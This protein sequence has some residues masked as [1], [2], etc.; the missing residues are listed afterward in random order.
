[1]H[2]DARTCPLGWGNV[3]GPAP[4]APDTCVLAA[5]FTHECLLRT[6]L[7]SAIERNY[8]VRCNSLVASARRQAKACGRL[9]VKVK[10]FKK[11]PV[12]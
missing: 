5:G 11:L 7:L 8:T 4:C 6:F 12:A 9:T 10:H 2:K 1:M 3:G